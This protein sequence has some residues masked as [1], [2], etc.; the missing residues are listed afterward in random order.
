M[1]ASSNYMRLIN[2][3]ANGNE[4]V[5]DGEGYAYRMRNE[6]LYMSSEIELNGGGEMG[7]L[8]EPFAVDTIF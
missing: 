1:V 4:S 5:S 7:L 6:G 8:L 2:V 3:H